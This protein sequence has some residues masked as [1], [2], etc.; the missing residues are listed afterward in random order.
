MIVV[1]YRYAMLL[2]LPAILMLLLWSQIS[3]IIAYGKILG[4][5]VF[6]SLNLIFQE[7]RSLVIYLGIASN[8]F[9]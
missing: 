1:L 9:I 2:L 8:I 6:L 3:I 7:K 4:M 5:F